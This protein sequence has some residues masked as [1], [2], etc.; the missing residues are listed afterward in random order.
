MY[1]YGPA[2]HGRTKAGR[3]A[4]TYIQQLCEDTGCCPEGLPR[5]KKDREEW[6]KCM[7]MYISYIYVYVYIYMCLY[8]YIYMW[9]SIYVCV[10][11]CVCVYIYICVC[12]CVCIYMYIYI[13]V[14][15]CVCLCL[16][17]SFILFLSS[18]FMDNFYLLFYSL[19]LVSCLH[20]AIDSHLSFNNFQALK[21][22]LFVS[23]LLSTMLHLPSKPF[24]V[25][26]FFQYKPLNLRVN[27]LFFKLQ[28]CFDIVVWFFRCS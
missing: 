23:F 10:C 20:L 21:K 24:E 9:G 19:N 5:T 11:V 2:T 15:V 22:S 8:I 1:S 18:F 6:Q 25:F 4:R 28:N 26:D 7:C 14:C 16:F 12:V 17:I 27:P 3:Q 13:C